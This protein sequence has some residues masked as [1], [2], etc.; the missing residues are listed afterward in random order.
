[1]EDVMLI[2]AIAICSGLLVIMPAVAQAP[3]PTPEGTPAPNTPAPP[4]A[5]NDDSRYSFHRV[6]DGYLRLDV[7]TGQVALCSRRQV[8]WACQVLPD[9]RI[10]LESEIAGAAPRAIG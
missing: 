8:G 5:E 1:M 2:R 6:Q 10:V 9:D 4:F 3:T 7:R